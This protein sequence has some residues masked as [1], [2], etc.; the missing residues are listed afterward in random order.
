MELSKNDY[1]CFQIIVAMRLPIPPFL[2]RLKKKMVYRYQNHLF[3]SD[4]WR[5]RIIRE[6]FDHHEITKLQ[7]GSG[8]NLLPGWLNTDISIPVCKAGALYLDAGQPFPFPDNSFDYVYSEHLFEHLDHAQAVNMLKE[9]RRVLKDTGTIRL[10]T[11]D[12]HFLVDLYLHPDTPVNKSYIKWSANGGGH[13]PVIPESP[14][15]VINKFHT[16]WGHQ[17]IYDQGALTDLMKEC[18]Y[19]NIRR[20]EIGKSDKEALRD[21]ERHF[22][23]MPYEFYELET[24]IFEAEI[25]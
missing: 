15:Y 17:I 1:F 7:I 19:L 5:N 6:Y 18:G 20:Y 4:S 25:R 24:M 3:R 12:F 10:V 2:R 13:C 11:P 21:V 23:H 14:L 9:C 8:M 22:H 16:A